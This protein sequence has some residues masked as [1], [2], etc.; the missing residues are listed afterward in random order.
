M[1]SIEKVHKL[2]ADYSKAPDPNAEGLELALTSAC[3]AVGPMFLE[4]LPD[5]PAILDDGLEQMALQL[6]ELR[7][8]GSREVRILA[9]VDGQAR[10]IARE[11]DELPAGQ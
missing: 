7:S 10:Q 3:L 2:A 8:D 4:L 1:N 11:P 6:L 5:D 9:D